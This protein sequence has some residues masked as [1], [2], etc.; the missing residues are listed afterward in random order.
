MCLEGSE[1]SF[2]VPKG[3]DK[4]LSCPVTDIKFSADALEIER[5][6]IKG[7]T[8]KTFDATSSILFTKTKL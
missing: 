2:C 7:Y 8:E 4:G 3:Q 5:L 6:K 1:D